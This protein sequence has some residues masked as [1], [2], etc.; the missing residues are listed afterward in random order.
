MH[1]W[2]PADAKPAGEISGFNGD[3]FKIAAAPG[4]VLVCSSDGLVRSYAAADRKLAVTFE[5]APDWVYCLSVDAKNRRALP[6]AATNESEVLVWDV[7]SGKIVS[8]FFCRA[9]VYPERLVK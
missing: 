6:A 7:G 9:G 2:G 4:L 1:A 3:P 8:R 5:Q